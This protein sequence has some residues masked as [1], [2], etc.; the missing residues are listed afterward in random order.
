[1]F[2]AF[3]TNIKS[4]L[5]YCSAVA[6]VLKLVYPLPVCMYV[7][8]HANVRAFGMSF[9]NDGFAKVLRRETLVCYAFDSLLV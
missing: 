3:L 7:C 8:A 9:V 1:M 4:G 5:T 2:L 6:K